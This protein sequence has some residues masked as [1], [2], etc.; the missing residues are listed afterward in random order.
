MAEGYQYWSFI[1]IDGVKNPIAGSVLSWGRP[2]VTV[3]EIISNMRK[4]M[5]FKNIQL[6]K[7]QFAESLLLTT[8]ECKGSKQQVAREHGCGRQRRGRRPTGDGAHPNPNEPGAADPNG[9]HR[10]NNSWHIAGVLHTQRERVLL[11]RRC[12]F[13]MPPPP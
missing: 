9:L 4:E 12:E 13:I 1:M 6:R 10:L 11:P 8:I 2:F 7:K 5:V 3:V